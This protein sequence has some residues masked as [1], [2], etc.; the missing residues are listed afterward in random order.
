MAKKIDI[1]FI[2]EWVD[3]S[4][5]ELMQRLVKDAVGLQEEAEKNKKTADVEKRIQDETY[6]IAF[7]K[8]FFPSV[9]IS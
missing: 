1:D 8:K 6:D 4:E 5:E 7:V 2:K 3:I 9:C